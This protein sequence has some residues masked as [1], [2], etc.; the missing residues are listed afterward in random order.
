M[1]PVD[2]LTLPR[3]NERPSPASNQHA[4]VLRYRSTARARSPLPFS[5]PC[6]MAELY[7]SRFRTQQRRWSPKAPCPSQSPACT[8][9]FPPINEA[10]TQAA[11]EPVSVAL[12][13]TIHRALLA[14]TRLSG[15]A[16]LRSAHWPMPWQ[17]GLFSLRR[18]WLAPSEDQCRRQTQSS[19]DLQKPASSDK[20]TSASAIGRSRPKASSRPSSASNARPHH[21][22]TT[23]A[24]SHLPGALGYSPIHSSILPRGRR[25]VAEVA[26]L[27]GPPRAA[28]SVGPA[29]AI[30]ART[31]SILPLRVSTLRS[32]DCMSLRRVRCSPPER[33]GLS[34]EEEPSIPE[35]SESAARAGR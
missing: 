32:L 11:Q 7:H 23:K 9:L 27:L 5:S 30:C 29:A 12:L 15:N 6:F 20:S 22:P 25:S 10:L 34:G 8:K 4:Q 14:D 31:S 24:P 16:R 13:K 28:K 33:R 3:H 35:A 1:M 21:Q 19:S 2:A 17:V 26:D 18:A